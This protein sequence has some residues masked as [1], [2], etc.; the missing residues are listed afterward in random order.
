MFPNATTK[1]GRVLKMCLH[2]GR[3]M[4]LWTQHVLFSLHRWEMNEWIIQ[5][6]EQG[7]AVVCERYSWSGMAYSVA[8][9]D[10]GVELSQLMSTDLGILLPDVVVFMDVKP[11]KVTRIGVSPL[12]DDRN[13]QKALYDAYQ[14]EEIWA[15]VRVLR[16]R[17][18]PNK[19]DSRK[20][21]TQC[22]LPLI[23]NKNQC[24]P[25]LYLWSTP[26][27]C[28]VCQLGIET[29]DLYQ[30][31]YGCGGQ[32][33]HWCMLEDWRSERDLI[34]Y[35][36]GEPAPILDEEGSPSGQVVEAEPAEQE[37]LVEEP[38][39]DD[40]RDAG[41]EFNE[42]PMGTGSVSCP[43]HGL[44][45]LSRDPNC[46]TC[47]RALGPMYRHLSKKYGQ[48]IADS[49]PTL[50]FD[51]SEPLPRAVTGARYLLLFVWRLQQV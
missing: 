23:P 15:G 49:T 44:D 16:H 45:H 32:V 14:M 18:S 46:E 30:H 41:L 42:A 21:L 34:C 13:F 24:E 36:C 35:A 9:S 48:Q 19:W 3:Q 11:D 40:A 27:E 10:P 50:S 8:Y 39:V 38:G 2:E 4:D 37:A 31:C 29:D 22:L 26:Q 1:L 6:H 43:E 20:R 12:F 51:F 33:H 28:Q 47:K 25:W 7:E 5:S 17:L